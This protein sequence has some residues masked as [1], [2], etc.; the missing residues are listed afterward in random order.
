MNN[1]NRKNFDKT[2]DNFFGKWYTVCFIT[3][4]YSSFKDTRRCEK[5]FKY[6]NLRL[7]NVN[8]WGIGTL[9]FT[10]ENNRLVVLDW[11]NIISM[12]PCN[13]QND[14]NDELYS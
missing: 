9:F 5:Y 3:K 13:I 2:I 14:D 11:R 10:D 6:A 8:G 1:E 4:D 12:I 7:D